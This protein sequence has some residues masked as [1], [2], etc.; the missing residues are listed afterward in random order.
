MLVR[1]SVVC[2]VTLAS[3]S[4]DDGS[5]NGATTDAQRTLVDAQSPD[6]SVQDTE[7]PFFDAQ[8]DLDARS[9]DGAPDMFLGECVR[10]S[11][12]D[13]GLFCNGTEQ[14]S[15]GQCYASPLTP[16][17]DNVRCTLDRCD[18][19]DESCMTEL[20]DTQCPPNYACDRKLGC[21]PATPC[22]SDA[23][24]DDGSM[25]NG[26]ESCQ[27]NRCAPGRPVQ[28]D[29]EIPCT[30]DVCIDSSGACESL[31]VHARC[32]ETQLCSVNDGCVDRPPCMRDDDCDDGSY[33]N[34]VETCDVD[35]GACQPGEAPEVDDGVPCT[36]DVCSDE[37]AMVLHRPTPAR[38]TDGQFC[39]GAEVCHPA[40]G[41]GPGVPPALSDGVG[42]TV[43]TCNEALDFV[44]HTPNDGAC[45]DDLFCNGAEVCHPLDG[46][47]AGDPPAL[48]DGIGCTVD[49]C[50]EVE[51]RVIHR[52]ENGNCDDGQ[53]CN[54]LERCDPMLDCQ[55]GQAP[56]LSDGVDCTEDSCDEVA[57]RT[58]HEPRSQRCDDGVFCNGQEVCSVQADC[59]PG[60]APVLD[61]GIP[62]TVDA[63][64][65]E[66]DRI[67]HLVDH[68]TCDDG[69]F[70][71]GA[72]VCDPAQ[73]CLAGVR[74]PLDD[75]VP[76][77][78]DRC[79]EVEDQI[80]HTPD[81]GQCSDGV[82]CN[83]AEVCDAIDDCQ[84]GE[85]PV[86]DDA[87][88]C[89]RD[90]C[91]E[92]N[93]RITHLPDNALCN[94]GSVCDGEE[95]CDLGRGCIN[96]EPPADGR[97]CRADPRSICLN[98]Q[99]DLSGCGDGFIDVN[100]GEECEDGNVVDG[101]GCS[102]G[103][104]NE[105]P[106]GG[107]D[108]RYDGSYDVAPAIQYSCAFGQVNINVQGFR[109]VRSNDTLQVF[110]DPG[111]SPPL[112]EQDPVP[113]DGTFNVSRT[114]PGGCEEVYSLR[115]QFDDPEGNQ[116]SATLNVV[117]INND[118]FSCL[119]SGCVNRSFQVTG[120]RQN[121]D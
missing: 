20:D 82:F 54:G 12:C 101:D 26:L 98:E 99:C 89:T 117:F 47:V 55:P 94:N 9:M 11:D 116:W 76:C 83:G 88:R 50:S 93:D 36:I 73:G 100:A 118:G 39:N 51:G 4:C 13:D 113:D 106:N 75:G 86:V 8:P 87:V 62:C 107:G 103:C 68:G 40:N 48:N 7:V 17:D 42:C 21:F 3:V 15:N 110:T 5:I 1:L 63:C 25:C 2:L 49:S 31:P 85:A 22:Q 108:D 72:E 92:A 95:V 105:A 6:D 115:G 96:G 27:M 16:C 23:D 44:E 60:T 71:N 102:A 121:G 57:D 24:C 28:C 78:L 77:T 30:V 109:F 53:F 41:C 74:P 29:D 66:R 119:L 34:G 79:D 120:T 80:T 38:C 14:C 33:C 52:V 46:C 35:N 18:E 70:C 10:N 43:D 104:R 97:V 37:L 69:A 65:E 111:P 56:N 64:D 67:T 84:A 45:D 90:A 61:D 59:M 91:D 81:H 32:I 112:M 58:V 19:T 114:I